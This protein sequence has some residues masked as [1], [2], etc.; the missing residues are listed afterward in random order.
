MVVWSNEIL[1]CKEA[2]FTL[3]VYLRC[4]GITTHSGSRGQ[5]L[6][7]FAASSGDKYTGREL[8]VGLV[9]RCYL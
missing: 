8:A 3:G 7:E 2:V 1:L 9:A 6:G 5:Y 4:V